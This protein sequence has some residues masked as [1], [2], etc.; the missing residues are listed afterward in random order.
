MFIIF[1]LDVLEKSPE[2]LGVFIYSLRLDIATAAF[3]SVIPTVAF[4]LICL[5]P[6][7]KFKWIFYFLVLSEVLISS[8]IHAG[9][10]IV[11]VEWKH[12]LTSKVFL[13]LF[14]GN[15]VVR[16]ADNLSILWFSLLLFVELFVG[17]VFF[18]Y[19]FIQ[20][21]NSFTYL[22]NKWD[23]FIVSTSTIILLGLSFLFARGGWQQIPINIDSAYYS[24]DFK[25]NDLSINSTYFFANSY[26]LYLI[27]D[28]E[29]L[30]PKIDAKEADLISKK[31]Y[32]KQHQD[33]SRILTTNRPNIVLIILEGWSANA[34]GCMSETKGAT[35][36]FD[37]LATDGL[38]FSQIYATN[39][40]SEIGHTSIL[41]GFPA[42]PETAISSYP[43]KH[44]KLTTINQSLKSSGYHS[45]YLFGG[46][47]SYGNIE[48][49]IKEHQMDEVW[50]EDDFPSGL[51][52]GKLTYYDEDVLSLF[53]DR[54]NQSSS[55]FFRVVFT[56][57]TH[58]PYDHPK[59]S[60]LHWTGKESDYMNSIAY[61]DQCLGDF[62]LKA[63][64]ETWYQNTLFIVVADHS[65]SC[66]THE[67]PYTVDFFK[68]PMLFYGEVLNKSYVGKSI[69]KIGSQADLASTLLTQL[70]IGTEAYPF[71]KNLLDSTTPEFAFLA[72]VRGYGFTSPQGKFIYHFDAKRYHQQTFSA[73][74]F[75]QAKKWSDALFKSYYEYF[76]NLEFQ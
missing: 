1:N 67:I 74:H 8:A 46:D 61:A 34:I 27:S 36:N 70:N 48:S 51:P 73:Q 23:I 32:N 44:R 7:R 72:T 42:L 26:L 60:T 3:M 71:S 13:H 21:I 24:N 12:K 5:L 20:P 45:G 50:D 17:F 65:H 43:E 38:L 29:Y 33:T 4:A 37:Q 47:L 31:L 59:N 16:T 25:L 63:K 35:P 76:K 22:K 18:W 15:E 14:H 19:S 54:I 58:A 52:H 9:E 69:G 10:V 55:P 39:T 62:F 68:I 28:L 49:F 66:P 53:L 2:W 57:S 11:Y 6:S 64:K 41:A 56:G 40:T 75:T 30:V